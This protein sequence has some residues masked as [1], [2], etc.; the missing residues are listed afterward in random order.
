MRMAT[1]RDLGQDDQWRLYDYIV[2]HFLGYGHSVINCTPLKYYKEFVW[3]SWLSPTQLCIP[4]AVYEV[5]TARFQ[6]GD[7]F[8][9]GSGIL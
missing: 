4:D 2:R 9:F 1:E 5:T 6:I 7:E 3:N 8:F